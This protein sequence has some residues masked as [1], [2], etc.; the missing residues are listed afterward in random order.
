[1]ADT[2]TAMSQQ[3]Q[4]QRLQQWREISKGA[5]LIRSK[6]GAIGMRIAL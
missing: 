5:F 4:L 1:M 3:A 2:I 6:P